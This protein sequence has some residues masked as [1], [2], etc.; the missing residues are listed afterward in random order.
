MRPITGASRGVASEAD[1]EE[2]EE[3]DLGR[4]RSRDC[5]CGDG[6]PCGEQPPYW[7]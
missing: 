5:D 4:G 1:E 3:E 7:S 6:L 2:E